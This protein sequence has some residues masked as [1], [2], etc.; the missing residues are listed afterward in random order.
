MIILQFIAAYLGIGALF[1]IGA[2]IYT[3]FSTESAKRGMIPWGFVLL[4][5][6]L[7]EILFWPISLLQY[8]VWILESLG[9]CSREKK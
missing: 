6:V 2:T 4:A 3:W 9:I 5:A 7:K 8:S 1:G